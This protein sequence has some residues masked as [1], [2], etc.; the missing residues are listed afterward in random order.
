MF[1][2]TAVALGLIACRGGDESSGSDA[3]CR[4]Y[5]S[6]LDTPTGAV[7]SCI[8]VVPVDGG[9]VTFACDSTDGAHTE[10]NHSVSSYPTLEA[11]VAAQQPGLERSAGIASTRTMTST[12]AANA[13]GFSRALRT[14]A[15]SYDGGL[16]TVSTSDVEI[17]LIDGG[18]STTRATSAYTAWDSNGRPTHG[19]ATVANGQSGDVT[20]S[21]DDARRIVKRVVTAPDGGVLSSSEVTYDEDGNWISLDL[22]Q[23]EFAEVSWTTGKDSRTVR[24]TQRACVTK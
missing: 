23:G 17:S 3:G 10:S 12:A 5:A 4:T 6:L 24:Q 11:F 1:A 7:T 19:V 2:A 21:Y 18:T 22:N 14:T 15:I 16:E 20:I 13:A 8:L 9:I